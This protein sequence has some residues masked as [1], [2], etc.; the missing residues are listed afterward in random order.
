MRLTSIYSRTDGVVDWNSS[1]V[2]PP[3]R[4]IEVGATHIGLVVNPDV[5]RHI[6]TALAS[7]PTPLDV[8]FE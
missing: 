2:D 1:V 7:T 6:G 5:Y 3:D 8:D 4:C